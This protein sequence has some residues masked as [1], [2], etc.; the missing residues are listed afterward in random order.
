MIDLP[1]RIAR[2]DKLT[3]ALHREMLTIRQANAPLLY[4]ERQAYLKA[5]DGAARGLETARIVLVKARQRIDA[6]GK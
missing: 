4:L 5:L 1:S 6:T 2:L 3:C